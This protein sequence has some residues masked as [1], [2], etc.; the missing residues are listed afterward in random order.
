MNSLYLEDYRFI[1]GDLNCPQESAIKCNLDDLPYYKGGN[2][3]F[4]V[5]ITFWRDENLAFIRK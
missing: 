5:T 1:F 2:R 4:I 3:L